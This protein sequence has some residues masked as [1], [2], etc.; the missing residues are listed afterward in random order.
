MHSAEEVL[1][2]TT[3]GGARSGSS[4]VRAGC[5]RNRSTRCY[6]RPL[7]PARPAPPAAVGR[8]PCSAAAGRPSRRCRH[9]PGR[10]PPAASESTESPPRARRSQPSASRPG[11]DA[12]PGAAPRR[13]RP[14]TVR[15]PDAGWLRRQSRDPGVR[16]ARTPPVRVCRCGG[17][18]A[19]TVTNR[20]REQRRRRA[21]NAACTCPAGNQR[22]PA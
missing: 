20:I 16:T 15:Q 18:P 21:R 2:C 10:V 22:K 3:S 13:G 14:H 1:R 4:P 19:G 9:S 7:S 12:A 5:Q 6:G 8:L 17:G 11:P